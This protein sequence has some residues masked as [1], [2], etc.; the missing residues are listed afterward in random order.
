MKVTG[1]AGSCWLLLQKPRRF[2][3]G[4]CFSSALAN[5]VV[6]DCG[7]IRGLSGFPRYATV[8][9]R[10]FER[11]L[12]GL[13]SCSQPIL[14]SVGSRELQLDPPLLIRLNDGLLCPW[15]RS[16]G[17]SEFSLTACFSTIHLGRDPPRSNSLSFHSHGIS[18]ETRGLAG[19]WHHLVTVSLS[20][21][22]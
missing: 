22:L 13:S 2:H 4:T 10:W 9:G 12:W 18:K 20:T 11:H 16:E 7:H 3:G 8:R 15:V 5:H 17:E 14:G 1:K 6:A 19:C 21:H